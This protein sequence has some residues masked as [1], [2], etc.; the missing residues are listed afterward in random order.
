M[1]ANNNLF[2]IEGIQNLLNKYLGISIKKFP[3]RDER[4]L[5]KYL[6]NKKINIAFDIGANVGQYANFL[7]NTGFSGKIY[8]FE[9][10][11]EA[12][13][14]LK[15]NMNKYKSRWEGINVGLGS[16]SGEVLINKSANSVSSSILP[17]LNHHIEAEKNSIYVSK[18][19]IKIITLDEFIVERE[20]NPESIFLKIDSQG[21]EYN[22]LMGS[23]NSLSYI[24]ALQIEMSIKPLY[25][26]EKS[27]FE[28]NDF[29]TK[30]GFKIS[31]IQ[32]GFANELECKLLQM[33]VIYTK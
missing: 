12:F 8:S 28:L 33:D 10:Q 25:D 2:D 32:S 16:S 18:E 7:I 11:K 29:I 26:G 31:G 30:K 17:I 21:Y 5:L 20:L 23:L 27:F 24:K 22:I 9:P 13:Y 3:S 14:S 1:L 15:K 6:N 4:R 19:N